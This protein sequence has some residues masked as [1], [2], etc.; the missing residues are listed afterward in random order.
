MIQPDASVLFP[1]RSFIPPK[2]DPI[3]TTQGTTI[4]FDASPWGG[5]AVLR[6]N[7][8]IVEYFSCVWDAKSVAHL[9]VATGKAQFQTFWEYLTALLALLTWSGYVA[10]EHVLLVGDNTASLQDAIDFKE[11][12]CLLAVARELALK[13]A[14]Y[15]W[16]FSV[17]HLAAEFNGVPDAL[18]RL[19]APPQARK[20]FPTQDLSNAVKR[21]APNLRDVWTMDHT[22]SR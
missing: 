17:G 19:E 14:R 9:N 11:K 2:V 21:T 16:R 13:A 22:L 4:Q 20:V 15:L 7:M 18:S 8:V 3:P 10:T 6:K 5:G 1:L 12:G